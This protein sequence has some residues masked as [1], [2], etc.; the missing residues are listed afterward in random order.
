MKRIARLVTALLILGVTA[1][2]KSSNVSL[3]KQ[4]LAE[5][6]S[7]RFDAFVNHMNALEAEELKDFYSDDPRFYWVED[8]Q[9][10]YANKVTLVASLDGLVD[11]LASSDMKVLKTKVDVLSESSAMLYAAYEQ[12][13]TMTA[14]GGF[15]ING[16]MTVQLQKEEG[17][18]RFLI[19]HSSTKKQR[20]G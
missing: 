8:G 6:I 2:N 7:T 14:G 19:G 12:A 4:A 5:E 16:A 10:Q 3:E 15:D 9:V 13:M 17:I 11:M 18:W 20:G 1:C